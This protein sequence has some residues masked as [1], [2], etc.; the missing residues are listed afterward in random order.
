[1]SSKPVVIIESPYAG[2]I[3]RNLAYA[4]A[5]VRDSILRGECPL[6]SHL[7]YTQPGILRDEV[8]EERELGM[9]LGWHAMTRA[10]KVVI[11]IDLGWSSGMKRGKEAAIAAFKPFEERSLGPSW[12][13][14]YEARRI[15]L[16]VHE[17]VYRGL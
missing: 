8:H 13:E 7:L 1:M 2:D 3:E 4:R 10:D 6:A 9:G 16:K 17:E 12:L 11:Y 14:T 15:A 5:A